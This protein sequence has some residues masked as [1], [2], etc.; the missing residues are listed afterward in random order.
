M[1]S[2]SPSSRVVSKILIGV[3]NV[4]T[5][6]MMR[7]FRPGGGSPGAPARPARA[8]CVPRSRPFVTRRPA[9]ARRRARA[10]RRGHWTTGRDAV[11][12]TRG[13]TCSTTTPPA[14][15]ASATS[16]VTAHDVP[17]SAMCSMPTSRS[18][19]PRW[20]PPSGCIAQSPVRTS[21]AW[22]RSDS[23]RS[24]CAAGR[25]A[26]SPAKVYSPGDERL[27]VRRPRTALRAARAP[28]PASSGRRDHAG[29]GA[30][31]EAAL[32]AGREYGVGEWRAR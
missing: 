10:G 15:T 4:F 2:S 3:V 21:S 1:A 13:L 29:G 27:E 8:S 20:V 22:S 32:A 9:G 6:T 14:S 31:C 16:S 5:L 19:P 28:A 26:G 24:A 30:R 11:E 7:P 17:S 23:C 18:R 25:P 12:C